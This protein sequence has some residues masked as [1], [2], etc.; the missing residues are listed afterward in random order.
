MGSSLLER[1]LPGGIEGWGK[2]EGGSSLLPRS[3]AERAGETIGREGEMG[4]L[5]CQ[6]GPLVRKLSWGRVGGRGEDGPSLRA[7]SLAA[8]FGGRGVGGRGQ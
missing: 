2:G 1:S 3:L 6:Q 8:G 7:R 4:I 5:A